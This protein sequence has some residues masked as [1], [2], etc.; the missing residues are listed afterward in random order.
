VEAYFRKNHIQAALDYIARRAY[1]DEP[2]FQ[3]FV[4]LR[5]A[6]IE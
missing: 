5:S 1:L 6:E 3:R 2:S 4:E